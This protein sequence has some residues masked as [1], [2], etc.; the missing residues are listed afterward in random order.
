[1]K[2]AISQSKVDCQNNLGMKKI[3][4]AGIFIPLLHEQALN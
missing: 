3:N 1:M 4:K 2:N